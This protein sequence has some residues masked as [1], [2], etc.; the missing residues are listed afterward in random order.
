MSRPD[1]IRERIEAGSRYFRQLE[2]VVFTT[3]NLSA[4][5]FE[6]FALPAA[7]G[8]DGR[9]ASARSAELH[10]RLG[11]VSCT[12]YYDPSCQPGTTGNYQYV[13]RPVPVRGRFFHPKLVIL[14]GRSEDETS[15]VYLAVSSANLT[16]SGWGRNAEAFGETWIHTR[17]QQSWQALDSLLVWLDGYAPL[18]ALA[19]DMDALVRIRR[20]LA[21]MPDRKRFSDNNSEAWSG[22]LDARLY[23]SVVHGS[24]LPAFMREGR[25]RRPVELQVFSPFWSEPAVQLAAFAARSSILVPARTLDA[26]SFGMS[27]K[28]AAEL[29]TKTTLLQSVKETGNRFWHMKAYRLRFANWTR[30]AVGSCNF[31]RS[32]LAGDS[33]NVEAMLV[34][35]TDPGW[36]PECQQ[37]NPDELAVDAVPEEGIPEPSPVAIVVA[38]DWRSDCWRWWLD[39]TPRVSSYSLLLPGLSAFS[40]IPGTGSQSG[41]PPPRGGRFTISYETGSGIKE[42]NGQIVE[43]NLDFSSRSY[44]RPL[45]ASEILDSWRSRMLSLEMASERERGDT[46]GEVGQLEESQTAAFDAVNLFDLYRSIRAM[47]LRLHNLDRNPELQRSCLVG[48]PDSVMALAHLANRDAEVPVVRYLVLKELNAL[49]FDWSDL[50]EAGLVEQITQMKE[51]ARDRCI[52]LLEVELGSEDEKAEDYLNWFDARLS[53]LDRVET[54]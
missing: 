3:F 28:Q 26:A 8:I 34:F 19:S 4:G 13:A 30:I 22:T 27:Q 41:T 35:D 49:L 2:G 12:V 23:A 14:A 39:A 42:W 40:L 25:K 53:A 29:D 38:W 11:Q 33:G 9:T 52:A 32:G 15:W 17:R 45:A 16:P 31:T 7:L 20:V 48:R 54:P 37:L 6:D 36:L 50:L 51:T 18:G 1:T 21:R 10:Q 5:F 47:R 46:A 43:L 44:G 24:G